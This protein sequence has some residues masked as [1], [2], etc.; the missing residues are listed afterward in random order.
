MTRHKAK[1][2]TRKKIFHHRDGHAH[3]SEQRALPGGTHHPVRV[4]AM[5]Y[6]ATDILERDLKSPHE[7]AVL[8]Q[9]GSI[10]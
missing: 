7:V 8:R 3:S 4:T 1:P 10:L 9:P 2:K 5:R 6:S